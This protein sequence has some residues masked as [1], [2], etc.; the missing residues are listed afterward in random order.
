MSVFI[1]NKQAFGTYKLRHQDCEDAVLFAIKT[2]Y[3]V[4]D[5]G[6]VYKNH[7]QVGKAIQKAIEQKICTRK[8][9]FITTKVLN[10]DQ[11]YG[12]ESIIK[13][14]S[15]SLKDLQLD[16]ID[17]IL[18]HSYMED[19]WEE[20]WSTLEELKDMS[21]CCHIGISNY[22]GSQ[23]ECLMRSPIRKTIPFINQIEIS[24]YHMPRKTIN[25]CQDLGIIVQGHTP[26]I[27]SEKMFDPLLVQLSCNEKISV[28]RLLLAW[29][30]S[31]NFYF[32]VR[33][34]NENHIKENWDTS[35]VPP[36][37]SKV[38]VDALDN[39]KEMYVTHPTLIKLDKMEHCAL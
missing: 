34:Q 35:V 20:A 18:L 11:K 4:I 14:I 24:P 19:K 22:Y 6:V 36:Q 7:V 15:K 30:I 12:R 27:K 23:V 13:S 32:A 10:Q 37:L 28:A 9:I 3:R 21:I 33:S 17:L 16:K 1:A 29:C 25:I 39:I 2:G 31:K 8:E 38:T 26:L 5:T